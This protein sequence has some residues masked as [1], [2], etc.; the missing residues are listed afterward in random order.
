MPVLVHLYIS[1]HTTLEVPG[2][3]DSK[4]ND[5]GGGKIKNM[6]HVTLNTPIVG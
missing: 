6:G 4:D 1:Q 5:W 3:S 2:F